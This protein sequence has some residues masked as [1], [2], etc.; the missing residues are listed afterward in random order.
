MLLISE[1]HACHTDVTLRYTFGS[2]KKGGLVLTRLRERNKALASTAASSG[3]RGGGRESNSLEE[4][5]ENGLGC[6]ISLW[7]QSGGYARKGKS[8]KDHVWKEK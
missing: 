7:R 4:R 8:K 3:G 2:S 6:S 5:R 1:R